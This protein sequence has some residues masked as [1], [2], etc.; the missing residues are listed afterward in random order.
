V[1]GLSPTMSGQPHRNFAVRKFLGF[2][3][4][5]EL[6]TEVFGL[7]QREDRQSKREWQFTLAAVSQSRRSTRISVDPHGFA[8]NLTEGLLRALYG[9]CVA[10]RGPRLPRRN[11]AMTF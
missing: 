3:A 11:C 8:I 10:Q 9:D 2:A 4:R 6:K 5:R 7:G 1:L